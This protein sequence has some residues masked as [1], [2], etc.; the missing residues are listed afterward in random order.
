[1]TQ[2]T[3]GYVKLE[4]TCPKC[5][6][7]NP[8][9]E[10]ACISCGA[11]QPQDVQF[12]QA[13]GQQVT[14][15]ETLKKAAEAGADIHCAFCGTRNPATA[16]VCAQCGADLKS[17]TRREAG[18]VVGA[19]QAAPVKQVACTHCGTMNPE[20][21]LKCAGCGASLVTAPAA[22]PSA[23]APAKTNFLG[24]GIGVAVVVILCICAIVGYAMLATPRES[25]A[26][27]VEAVQWQTA[28]QIEGLGPVQ[29]EGWQDQVPSDAQL[30]SCQDQVRSVQD[31]QP[32]GQNYNKVCGTPYTVDTGS[33][34]GKVVQDCQFEVLEPYCQYTVLAWQVVDQASR[35]GNDL[36]PVWPEPTLSG[37][38]RLGD[39]SA[40][41]I[42]VFET[43][44]GQYTYSVGSLQEFQQFTAGSEWTL[45]INA[46]GQIVSV[47]PVR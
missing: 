39:Q 14:Q 7:R 10:I 18:R 19:Y 15:D 5:G 27:V 41:F 38:Q 32:S 20:T 2:E 23:K 13:Q 22:A 12:D 43:D 29:R 34:V 44:K 4:W 37:D 40:D 17:G 42:V 47:E 3:L 46:L 25:Q 6:S 24:I 1:M 21:A 16:A 28:V 35:S 45:N 9:T 36:A 33:G 8:A 26:G 30:G 31:T 11:A